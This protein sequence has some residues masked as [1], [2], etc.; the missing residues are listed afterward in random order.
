[1]L[2]PVIDIDPSGTGFTAIAA[3]G[4]TFDLHNSVHNT[5]LRTH[6]NPNTTAIA[7]ATIN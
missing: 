3:D 2:T 1:L 6:T 7:I 5:T 4:G